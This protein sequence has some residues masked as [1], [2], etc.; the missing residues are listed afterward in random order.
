MSL[1]T[2]HQQEYGE[3]TSCWDNGWDLLDVGMKNVIGVIKEC[4]GVLDN[5]DPDWT[6]EDTGEPVGLT[7]TNDGSVVSSTGVETTEDVSTTGESVELS[8]TG[9]GG[10]VDVSGTG[11]VYDCWRGGLVVVGLFLCVL[12]C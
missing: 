7:T 4:L 6:P 8:T 10:D 2:T 12:R 1:D 9:V 11:H 3:I 5:G